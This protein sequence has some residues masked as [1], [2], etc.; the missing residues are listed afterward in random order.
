M[1][2]I[3]EFKT[4]AL[5][6]NMMDLAVG[7]I[8][9]GA[10]NGI[11]TSLVNDVIMPFVSLFIGKI[12]FNNLFVALDGN[13]YT[14]LAAAKAAG[15]SVICYGSFITAL[16]NFLI[17]AFVV[18]LM[19]KGLNKLNSVTLQR[20]AVPAAPTTKKCPFCQSEID[21]HAVRCPHCT[22]EIPTEE[23]AEA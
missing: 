14:T 3:K 13:T 21:I 23:A 11:V 18:F 19:V 1:G 10:F 8:I 15:A 5:K 16:I 7:V 20:N 2:F 4:F 6:G 22:S 9:G 17:L 12:D